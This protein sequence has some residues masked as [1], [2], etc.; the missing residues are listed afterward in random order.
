MSR[1]F[2]RFMSCSERRFGELS[3]VDGFSSTTVGERKST[4]HTI[5]RHCS[6]N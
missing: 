4:C 5:P 3:H 6:S 2:S 1:D